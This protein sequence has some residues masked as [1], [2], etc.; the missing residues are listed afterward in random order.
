MIILWQYIDLKWYFW[1]LFLLSYEF[2]IVLTWMLGLNHF[3]F[4]QNSVV[5]YQHRKTVYLLVDRNSIYLMI[6]QYCYRW[7]NVCEKEKYRKKMKN[8]KT[9]WRPKIKW[10]VSKANE[11]RKTVAAVESIA[12]LNEVRENGSTKALK[13][14]M[15]MAKK[16]ARMLCVRKMSGDQTHVFCR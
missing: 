9:S 13:L 4:E 7:W 6:W 2:F 15:M 10:N 8:G 11:E 1:I 3:W 12:T 16:Y 14:I 5:S